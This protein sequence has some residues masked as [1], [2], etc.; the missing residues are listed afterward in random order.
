MLFHLTPEQ[1]AI[2]DAVRGTLAETWA[3]DKLHAFADADADFH[4]ESWDAL[5]ALGVGG[6]FGYHALYFAALR[7]AS[8]VEA[9]LSCYLWPLLIVL[10]SAPRWSARSP[11]RLRRRVR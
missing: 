9:G 8:P 10:F 5:M 11:A 7:L 3:V 6:L 2:Q 4:R 1:T